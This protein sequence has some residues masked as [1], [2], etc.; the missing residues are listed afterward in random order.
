MTKPTL[1]QKTL[2]GLFWSFIDSGAS[3]VIQFV[4]GV[5]LARL[6][7]PNEF[8]L[9]GMLAIFIALSNSF[10]DSG[11][12]NALIRKQQCTTK[13]YSTV[14]YFNFLIGF[15]IYFVL[16]YSSEAIAS[17]FNEPQ[18]ESI[19]KVYG[20]VVIIDS[21]TIIQKTILTK[22]INFRLQARIS[23][24]ASVL[25]GLVAIYLANKGFG[26]WSLVWQQITRQGLI[27]ILL[28][29]W[30]NWMPEIVF[31]KSS[32]NSLFWFG[33]KLMLSGLIYTFFNNL[34]YFVI[35]K[36]FSAQELGF[37]TRATQFSNLPSQNLQAV[38]SRVSY[39][40]L[41]EIQDEPIRLKAAYQRLIR[42]IVYITFFL[43]L[44]LAAISEPLVIALIGEKWR[45]S[46]LFL[47]LLC[48]ISM[49]Y[50]LH[51]VNLNMLQVKGRSDLFLKLEI[52]KNILTIPVVLIGVFH[53]I[54]WMLVCMIIHTLISYYLNSYWS[55]KLI[56]YSFN[57]Q[58]R[59][60][61]PSLLFSIF[62]SAVLY[63]INFLLPFASLINLIILIFTGF[64]LFISVSEMTH[65]RDYYFI[66]QIIISKFMNK[67]QQ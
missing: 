13:D 67:S 25:S 28:W 54:K 64:I 49:F 32:F 58:I 53:G 42:S 27:T 39:P 51:A 16:F 55:G 52:I 6:L 3:K 59:D 21:L 22:N 50:P 35:G 66:K 62:I 9:I 8:G 26:V 56:G 37:Y 61:L 5:V 31:S 4:I 17:L 48:F 30:N 1:K 57:E 7:S 20:L 47:Q 41:S 14:F 63:F 43:M 38:I 29:Y 19:L 46:I 45:Q 65:N 60:I 24:I 12:S 11:F 2:N 34:Y 44:C 10:I 18:L 33:S 15:I 40:I 36:F 23:V